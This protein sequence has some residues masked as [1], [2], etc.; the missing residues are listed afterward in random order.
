MRVIVPSRIDVRVSM[1]PRGADPLESPIVNVVAGSL[2]VLLL[3]VAGC[4]SGPSS[5]LSSPPPKSPTPDPRAPFPSPPIAPDGPLEPAV[6]AAL[7]TLVTSLLAADFD[8]GA[9]ESVAASE[10]ARLGWF[11]SDLLRFLQGTEPQKALVDAFARLTGVDHRDDPAF[12][13]SPWR[14]VT[15]ELIAWDLPPPPGYRELKARIFVEVEPRWEPFFADADATIDW[16]HLSWGGVL[17][18][19]RPIGDTEPCERGC[20]PALDD[21]A[22]T[23]ATD[24]DWYPDDRVVFGL[25]IGTDEVALPRNIMEVHEMVNMTIGGRRLGIPYCTLCGS[26]QAYF[27]DSVP[28]GIAVPVLRTSGLLTR[29]NK[30]M[31]DLQTNSVLDTFTGEALS[32]PLQDAGVILEE[33][34]VVVTTWGEWKTAHPATRIVARDGGLGRVYPSDPLGGRDDNGPI[35]PIGDVDPRLPVQANVVGVIGPDGTPV[36]FPVEQARAA[37]A[38]GRQVAFGDI[39]V[40]SDGGGLRARMRDGDE[41]PAHQAFWFAWSQFNPDTAVWTPLIR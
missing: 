3:V 39:E 29:S 37:L 2:G 38:D 20:I 18:D 16:R 22:L 6:S 25:A 1:A 15:D 5:A 28:A 26:A 40:W 34:T 13:A 14:T 21:P 32:G 23:V 35:F 24:G 10:D 12:A 31:Y 17:I 27:T 4:A 33:A 19:D 41:L 36:A 9:L 30:V 7:D 8:Y 11:V